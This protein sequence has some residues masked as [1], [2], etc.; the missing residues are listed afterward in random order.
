M[1]AGDV[2]GAV[3]TFVGTVVERDADRTFGR[4]AAGGIRGALAIFV[5]PA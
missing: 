2:I 4:T 5:S 3:L 1:T